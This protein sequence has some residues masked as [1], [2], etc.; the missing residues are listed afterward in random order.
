LRGEDPGAELQ[1]DLFDLGAHAEE[2]FDPQSHFR[3]A[4]AGEYLAAFELMVRGI[5]VTVAAEGLPYDLLAD[6]DGG[7]ARVQV[8]TASSPRDRG[9]YCF[10]LKC[11]SHKANKRS[12]QYGPE[13]IDLFA[14]VALDIRRVAFVHVD[15]AAKRRCLK[16]RPIDFVA[17]DVTSATFARCW[18]RLRAFP[19]VP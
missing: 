12:T 8:K 15:E 17:H 13:N 2:R 1:F 7:I 5:S 9:Q 6:H 14:V 18:E 10:D 4:K 11:G 19:R 16:L 3:L